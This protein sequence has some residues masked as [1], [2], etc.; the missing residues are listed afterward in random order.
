MKFETT[1]EKSTLSA[2]IFLY[3]LTKVKISYFLK[4]MPSECLLV[5]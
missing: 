3:S 2:P 5:E 4:A 1:S